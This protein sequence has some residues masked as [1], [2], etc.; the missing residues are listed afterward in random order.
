MTDPAGA[1]VEGIDIE[2]VTEWAAERIERAGEDAGALAARLA[3]ARKAALRA[4]AARVETAARLLEGYSYKGVLARGFAVVRDAHTRP[5]VSAAR[6]R[7]GA[8]LS[9]EFRDGSAD[10]VAA[11]HPA[12]RP[13][14]RKAGPD[15]ESGGQTPLL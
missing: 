7:P 1:A 5:L 10:A 11:G 14:R 3:R 4:R 6:V 12:R 9:L 8:A 15:D 13:T 2:R